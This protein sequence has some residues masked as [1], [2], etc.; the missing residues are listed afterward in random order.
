[1]AAVIIYLTK[2]RGSCGSEDVDIG[3]LDSSPEDGDSMFLGNVGICLLVHAELIPI[4]TSMRLI[5]HY[6]YTKI[7]QCRN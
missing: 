2:I 6:P 4:S 3:L 7:K 1:M 5:V